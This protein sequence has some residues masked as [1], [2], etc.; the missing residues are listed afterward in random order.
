MY[1]CGA[2]FGSAAVVGRVLVTDSIRISSLMKW[3][4]GQAEPNYRQELL[5]FKVCFVLISP[6]NLRNHKDRRVKC[7][8]RDHRWVRQLEVITTRKQ[9]CSMRIGSHRSLPHLGLAGD[10][11]FGASMWYLFMSFRKYFRSMSASRA[12]CEMLY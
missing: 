4:S 3:G 5:R 10:L 8:T 12:A 6:S 2:V 11:R 1:T 7:H 9:F